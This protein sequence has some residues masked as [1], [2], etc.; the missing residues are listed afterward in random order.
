MTSLCIVIQII[1]QTTP[2]I[3]IDIPEGANAE[4]YRFI[5][6]FLA[7]IL[8]LCFGIISYLAHQLLKSKSEYLKRESDISDQRVKQN[9]Y[10][11]T[12]VKDLLNKISNALNI[13]KDIT[14]DNQIK[15]EEN[16]QLLNENAILIHSILHQVKDTKKE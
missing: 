6:T 1:L 3:T 16:K 2:D 13:I 12:S 11:E 7:S 14:K 9:E 5:A 10:E 8:I 4:T 15:V